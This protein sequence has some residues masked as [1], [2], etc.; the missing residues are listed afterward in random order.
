MWNRVIKPY[1]LEQ[2]ETINNSL[3]NIEAVQEQL[4]DIESV[5]HF[6]L[7]LSLFGILKL[8]KLNEP[9]RSFQ[10]PEHA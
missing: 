2:K 8:L 4:F 6:G 3:K 10:A 5:D 9:F 1:I 7:K